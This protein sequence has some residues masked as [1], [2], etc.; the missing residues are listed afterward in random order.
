MI[1]LP[2]VKRL[3]IRFRTPSVFRKII[4]ALI[5]QGAIILTLSSARISLL[6]SPR[7]R[8]SAG[9]TGLATVDYGRVFFSTTFIPVLI[10]LPS[11]WNINLNRHHELFKKKKAQWRKIIFVAIFHSANMRAADDAPL[12]HSFT[13]FIDIIYDDKEI[14]NEKKSTGSCCTRIIV[15]RRCQC[16][17]NL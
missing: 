8:I 12:R 15:S 4:I 1:N 5:V 13:P 6:L 9:V 16:G 7:H 10:Y 2:S 3:F 17:R 11:Q 14:D